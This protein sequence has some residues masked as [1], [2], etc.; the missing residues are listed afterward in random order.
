MLLKKPSEHPDDDRLLAYLDGELSNAQIR[1]VRDHLRACWTCR[2][3][4]AELESQ[5]EAISRLLSAKR[6]FESG[7]LSQA[8]EG[9][10]RWRI[11]LEARR[12]PF[13]ECRKHCQLGGT[14][15][16]AFEQSEPDSLSPLFLMA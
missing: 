3:A 12:R 15:R 6:R 4:L 13:F 1:S 9:F 7:R 8:K 14:A 2:S 16:M 5:V 10:L 11:A